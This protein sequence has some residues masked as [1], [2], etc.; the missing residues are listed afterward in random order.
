MKPGTPGFIGARL[1]EAREARGLPAIGLAD[2][3]GVS[4]AAVSQYENGIQSPRPEVMERI[5]KT[6]RLPDVYFRLPMGK[7]DVGA[8]FYRSMSAATKS[9]RIRA[10]RRYFWLKAIVGYLREFVQLPAVNFPDFDLSIDPV[11]I[12]DNQI[13]ELAIQTRRFWNI[14]DGPINNVVWL[15]ENNGAIVA[16]DELGAETLDAFS[17]FCVGDGVPYVVLGSDKAVAARSRFDA[18]HELGHIILHR[19]INKTHLSRKSDH[20]LIEEQ[21]HRFAGAFLVPAQAFASE[22]YSATLDALKIL[23]AKWRVSIAMMIKRAE[24]LNFISPQ[25][26][27]R[28]WISYS[29]RRW[30]TKEPLDDELEIEQPRV[31]RRAFELL[32]NEK[33]QT[34]EQILSHLPFAPHD[35]EILAGIPGFLSRV[36]DDDGPSVCVLKEGARKRVSNQHAA[37]TSGQII[38]FP[39]GKRHGRS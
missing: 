21:A 26:V 35:I 15:L 7:T 28:L 6:L 14:G 10:E 1:R 37:E 24:N 13:E 4:R 2:L 9:A 39:G 8:I 3:I 33:I 12:S 30:R 32:I 29:R 18:A 31:L 20:H 19:K 16:R 23:K 11:R 22:F 38:E 36:S 27:R 17:E 5:T 34:R 25:Q